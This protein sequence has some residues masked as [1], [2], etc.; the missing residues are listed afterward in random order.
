[1]G[2]LSI[3]IPMENIDDFFGAKP[4][5]IHSKKVASFYDQFT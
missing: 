2:F 3:I 5:I 1:M 4:V